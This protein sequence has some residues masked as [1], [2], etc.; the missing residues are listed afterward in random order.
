MQTIRLRVND[1][2]YEKLLWLLKKF[3]KSDI[4]LIAEDDNFLEEKAYLHG[5]LHDIDNGDSKFYSIEQLEVE[6]EKVIAKHE[7]SI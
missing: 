5:E 2:I 7:N 1:K 3:N 4:E 6:L